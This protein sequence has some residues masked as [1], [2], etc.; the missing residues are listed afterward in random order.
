MFKLPE[1]NMFLWPFAIVAY[2]DVFTHDL[3]RRRTCPCPEPVLLC[4]R[5][6]L[7]LKYDVCVAVFGLPVLWAANDL[8][9]H[10]FAD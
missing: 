2:R 3:S 6:K 1:E 10:S 8:T 5:V 7:D 9:G 4:V